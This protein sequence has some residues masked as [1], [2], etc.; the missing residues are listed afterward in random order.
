VA[1]EEYVEYLAIIIPVLFVPM[2]GQTV[3]TVILDDLRPGIV[4]V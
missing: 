4:S 1:F 3:E 2:L